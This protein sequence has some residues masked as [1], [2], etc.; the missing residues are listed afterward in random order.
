[1]N[2]IILLSLALF[3]ALP[4]CAENSGPAPARLTT[5]LLEHT[6][7][8]FIDGYP[9]NLSPAELGIA[10]ERYQTAA[11]RNPQPFFGW[12]VN[13]NQPNTLQTA[14]RILV[15]S[16]SESLIYGTADEPEAIIQ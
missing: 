13:S 1:M 14:Y 15:A 7:R 5:D 11:I 6:N 16:S 9:S 10:V 3:V 2:R 12:V 8:V 4:V